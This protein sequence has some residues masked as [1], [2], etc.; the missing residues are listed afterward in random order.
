MEGCIA[1]ALDAEGR[2]AWQ[3]GS[4]RDMPEGLGLEGAFD[5]DGGLSAVVARALAGEALRQEVVLLGRPHEL[6]LLPRGGGAGT[7]A[8]GVWGVMRGVSPREEGGG[9]AGRGAEVLGA[10][11][12][13]R[14]RIAQDLHDGV[15]S[16]LAAASL[17]VRDLR[18]RGVGE[19][20]PLEAVAGLLGQAL[21]GIHDLGAGL[22]DADL[23]RL[24]LAGALEAFVRREVLPRGLACDVDLRCRGG[25]PPRAVAV[26]LLRIAQEALRNAVRHSRARRVAVRLEEDREAVCLRVS[27]DG[28]GMPADLEAAE[29]LGLRLLRARARAAGGR[30]A[31]GRVPGGGTEVRC[32]VPRSWA[33]RRSGV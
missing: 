18:R 12:R 10:V 11:E 17:A 4:D 32:R 21:E 13:E 8:R 23:D 25:G 3:V 28:V 20:G 6:W 27:D 16:L 2:L 24:G 5:G 14:E 1:F 7:A 26:Q 29:G 22:L 33:L 19:A 30:L 9:E 15:G 31:V